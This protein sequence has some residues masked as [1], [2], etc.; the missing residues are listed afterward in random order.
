MSQLESTAAT[1]KES[2]R[3]AE[4]EASRLEGD[5]DRYKEQVAELQN[6]V[7]LGALCEVGWGSGGVVG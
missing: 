1:A 3:A 2:L 7:G 4:Q 6:Q 5:R